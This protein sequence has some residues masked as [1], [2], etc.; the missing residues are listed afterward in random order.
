[1]NSCSQGRVPHLE[2]SQTLDDEAEAE[3]SQGQEGENGLLLRLNLYFPL[4]A[5]AKLE[6]KS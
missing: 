4:R 6:G 5:I 1:M 3:A 2:E